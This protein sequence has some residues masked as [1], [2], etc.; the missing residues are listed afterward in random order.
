MIFDRAN[1]SIG[2]HGHETATTTPA[3]SEDGQLCGS[4]DGVGDATGSKEQSGALCDL[5]FV[6]A[7]REG[8]GL[9]IY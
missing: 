9:T 5:D 8:R 7:G 2:R 4:G 6:W 1:S 3:E